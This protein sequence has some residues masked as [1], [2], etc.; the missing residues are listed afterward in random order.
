VEQGIASGK[1]MK[2]RPGLEQALAQMEPG[3]VLVSAKLDRVSRSLLDFAA[4]LDRA[5]REGWSLVV[6]DAGVDTTTPNGRA[7]IGMIAVFAQL[8]RELISERTRDALAAARGRG[9]QLGRPITGGAHRDHLISR[10]AE[11][12]SEHRPL[13]EIAALLEAD[14][15]PTVTGGF[16]WH[17]TTV[18]RLIAPAA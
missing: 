15:E 14:G 1:S 7:M 11:L 2:R 8:E 9:Q 17:P 18:K 13:A 6:L 5:G 10:I 4:L 3:R 16:R 12:R